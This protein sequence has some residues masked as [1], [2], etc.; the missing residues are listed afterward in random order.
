[1]SRSSSTLRRTIVAGGVLAALAVSA[2]G[3]SDD[4]NSTSPATSAATSA[5]TTP[6]TPAAP[7]S[8]S[9]VPLSA[10]ANGSLAFNTTKLTAQAGAVALVMTNPGSSGQPHGIAISGNGVN[11]HGRVV[12][13]GKVSTVTAK[14]KAGTYTFFCPVPGHEEAGMKGTLTVN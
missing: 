10:A 5:A 3:S 13:P 7:A 4:D 9:R 12:S 11:R 14:L 2:C 6:A 8:A 1:M